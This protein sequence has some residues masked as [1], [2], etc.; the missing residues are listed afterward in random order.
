[1]K[2]KRCYRTLS[3]V[4]MPDSAT[5]KSALPTECMELYL[6][7]RSLDEHHPDKLHKIVD[8]VFDFMG[9]ANNHTMDY[10]S[11]SMKQ[12]LENTSKFD[13]SVTG[14]GEDLGKASEPV[15]GD[16][17]G[18]RVTFIALT[19]SLDDSARAGHD[20]QYV[21]GRPGVNPLRF[22]VTLL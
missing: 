14:A 3:V 15:Y 6:L 2:V 21:P 5:W 16:F 7:R 9:F 11:Q 13:I 18:G 22:P 20:S 4:A 17:E 8:Y 12:T 1:M 10:L 19:S